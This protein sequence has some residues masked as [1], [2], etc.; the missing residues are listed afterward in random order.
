M[1]DFP[2][3][4]G[5]LARL[6]CASADSLRR[7]DKK[8]PGLGMSLTPPKVSLSA[9]SPANATPKRGAAFLAWL[10]RAWV[11]V[12][13]VGVA[14][15]SCTIVTLNHSHQLSAYD[16]WVY[17]DAV[18]KVPTQGI[19]HQGEYIG[20]PALEEMACFGDPYGARGEKCTGPKGD[21]SD[22]A[23][24][25]LG[26]KT[27]AD[28]Y[29]PVYF[30]ITWVVAQPIRWVTGLDLLTA[31]RLTGFFWLG[32][33]LI[34]FYA[35]TRELKIHRLT[36]LGLG[37]VAIGTVPSMYAF[38]YITTDAPCFLV[39]AGLL[40]LGVRFVRGTFSGWWLIPLSA[41]AVLLKITNIFA[42]GLLAL[43]ML[44]YA[45]MK[46]KQDF[47]SRDRAPAP[48][49]IVLIA[50]LY[51]VA[52]LVAEVL[53]LAIRSAISIGPGPNQGINSPLSIRGLASQLTTF[54]GFNSAYTVDGAVM[55]PYAVLT[56]TGVF[57][58]LM[59]VRGRGIKRALSIS[60]AVAV[61]FFPPILVVAMGIA[62]GSA[63]PVSTRYSA[64][65]MPAILVAI[66]FMIQNKAWRYI[67]LSYGAALVAIEIAR[68]F[69]LP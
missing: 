67:L 6:H 45:I 49:R 68:S 34:A 19:V 55:L 15:L 59:T 33:G 36:A 48:P 12:V 51:T 65:L 57:G 27:T 7:I 18:T 28:I 30:D 40:Y 41:L 24:Y 8:D 16:E 14:L 37:L 11:P 13:L 61:V 54:I 22:H 23:V 10:K 46:R 31:A 53:W 64:P 29:A 5:A 2:E 20:E 21:Y 35:L 47:S 44:I 38:T 69:Y 66:G 43:Y 58:F 60:T 9:S 52:A 56:I 39:G 42:V 4:I 32:A 17:Y 1:P 50:V 26:G 25:P 3:R 63:F 62:L